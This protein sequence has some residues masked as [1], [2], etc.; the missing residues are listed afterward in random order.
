MEG[1][2]IRLVKPSTNEGFFI[3]WKNVDMILINS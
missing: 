2:E 3:V 1:G